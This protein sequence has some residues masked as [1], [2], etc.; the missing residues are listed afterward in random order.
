MIKNKENLILSCDWGTSNFRLYL[1]DYNTASIL[2]TLEKPWGAVEV[3]NQWKNKP[4]LIQQN[5]FFRDFLVKAV[6]LLAK[7]TARNLKGIPIAISGMASSTIGMVEVPY[8]KVP[9]SLKKPELNY[10]Y[11]E[12]SSTYSNPIYV[13]GGLQTDMDVIRGEEVQLLGLANLLSKHS[14]CMLPGTHSK[15]I[16]IENGM[17]SSFNTFMTGELFHLMKN[18][19]ILKNS[20]KECDTVPNP[21]FTKGVLT[22]IKGNL[23]NTLFHVRTKDVLQNVSHNKNH[24]FLSGLLIGSELREFKNYAFPVVLGGNEKLSQLYEH[25]LKTIAPNIKVEI[26][27]P[28]EMEKAIPKAHIALLNQIKAKQ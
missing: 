3:Y 5:D 20:V 9:L 7:M 21:D 22:A 19:S 11:F 12:T 14:C 17:A 28:S 8:T 15:H 10:S 2:E 13:F 6:N 16:I 4:D 23:L 1:T 26:I 24:T 27:I 25:A 18:H